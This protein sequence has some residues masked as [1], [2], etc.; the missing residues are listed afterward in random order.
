MGEFFQNSILPLAE[1]LAAGAVTRDVLLAPE[2]GGWPLVDYQQQMLA[3][4]SRWAPT[5]SGACRGPTPRS[6]LRANEPREG[7]NQVAVGEL[8]LKLVQPYAFFGAPLVLGRGASGLRVK[9]P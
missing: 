9:L 6:R 1:L 4:F 7:C 5:T 8:L 2:V 3:A